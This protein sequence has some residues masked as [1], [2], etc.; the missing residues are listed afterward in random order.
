[1]PNRLNLTRTR[2]WA[3]KFVKNATKYTRKLKQIPKLFLRD[4][5]KKEL[6]E[7]KK[8]RNE[9][10]KIAKRDDALMAKEHKITLR[11]DEKRAVN[12]DRCDGC[13]SKKKLGDLF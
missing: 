1:M 8:I 2:Q 11:L 4:N 10:A 9:R 3:E 6:R 13:L 7:L 12:F 5:I